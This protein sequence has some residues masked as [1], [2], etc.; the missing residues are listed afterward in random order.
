M[1]YIHLALFMLDIAWYLSIRNGMVLNGTE[2][3]HTNDTH[4]KS[5]DTIHAANFSKLKYYFQ[6]N[7][8]LGVHLTF[9]ALIYRKER[10]QTSYQ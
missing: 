9:N 7:K 5:Y 3:A 10:N 1:C 6:H 8:G 4:G 2:S